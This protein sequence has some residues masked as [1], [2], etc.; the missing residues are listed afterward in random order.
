MAGVALGG[1]AAPAR[2][3]PPGPPPSDYIG[4]LQAWLARHKEYPSE[5]RRLGQEGTALLHFSIDR[6]GRVLAARLQ[7]S[8]GHAVL[9]REVLAMIRRADPLPP[10]PPV[11]DRERLDLVVPVQFL[12]R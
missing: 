11:V 8:S 5:A 7:R 10:L 1:R 6:S 2:P 4:Q 3:G 9:D 12:L